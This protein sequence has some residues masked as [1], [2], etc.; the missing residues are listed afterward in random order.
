MTIVTRYSRECHITVG[1]ASLTFLT[2]VCLTIWLA[3]QTGTITKPG[4]T[5]RTACWSCSTVAKGIIMIQQHEWLIVCIMFPLVSLKFIQQIMVVE[6]AKS[7]CIKEA[8]SISI[9]YMYICLDSQS[10]K[11]CSETETVFVHHLQFTS[12]S[13]DTMSSYNGVCTMWCTQN[14][15]FFYIKIFYS[16]YSLF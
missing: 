11:D 5:T 8:I 16:F 10:S 15:Y 7:N 1:H 4:R 9:L 13:S 6:I 3:M 14:I 2:P 12:L